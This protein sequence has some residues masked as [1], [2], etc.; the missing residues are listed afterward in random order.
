MIS[1]F[2][3]HYTVTNIRLINCPIS[4]VAYIS[5]TYYYYYYYY[6]YLI[7]FA[8]HSEPSSGRNATQETDNTTVF[9]H[10]NCNL[11]IHKT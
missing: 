6:Y 8:A 4:Q 7:H 1:L 10:E 5:I 9:Q 2:S 11:R 3:V